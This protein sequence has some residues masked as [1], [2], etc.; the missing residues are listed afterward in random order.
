MASEGRVRLPFPESALLRDGR[1]RSST[2][3]TLPPSGGS[4]WTG[5]VF[6]LSW[7]EISGVPLLVG[8]PAARLET[9][10]QEF[11]FHASE[12]P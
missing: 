4:D 11:V 5:A 12:T 3:D 7:G 6:R 9:R 8:E 2:L 10:T 1:G